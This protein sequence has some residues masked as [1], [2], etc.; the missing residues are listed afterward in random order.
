V[1]QSKLETL[2]RRIPGNRE[3]GALDRDQEGT[4]LDQPPPVSALRD[5]K[6][7]RAVFDGHAGSFG[8]DGPEPSARAR[9]E[10]ELASLVE[11][12]LDAGVAGFA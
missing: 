11:E 2:A 10:Q 12:Q 7:C 9:Q 1:A 5:L 8:V 6:G 3:D 4:G